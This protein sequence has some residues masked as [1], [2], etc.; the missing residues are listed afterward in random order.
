MSF[1]DYYIP[2]SETQQ[3]QF[4][5]HYPKYDGRNTLIAIF[6][7]GVDISLPGLQKTSTGFPKIVDCFD[8][9]GIRNVDISTITKAD[10]EII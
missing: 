1:C 8:F 3:A 5:K 10:E 7:T 9:T 4:L 2:K 6:D